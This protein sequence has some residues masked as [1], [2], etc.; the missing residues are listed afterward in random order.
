MPTEVATEITDSPAEALPVPAAQSPQKPNAALSALKRVPKWAYMAAISVILIIAIFTVYSFLTSEPA[1][2]RIVY[3]HNFRSADIS[4]VVDGTVVYSDTV[5]GGSKRRFGIL[6]KTGASLARTVGVPTGTHAVQ[7]HV[8]AA[9]DGF[10]Q[11]KVSYAEFTATSDNVLRITSLKRG[12]LNLAFEGGAVSKAPG[13]D[14]DSK[15]YSKSVFSVFFSVLGT[16]LSASV[17]FMVQ[18]FWRSHKQRLAK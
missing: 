9:G 12:G 16:M 10:D 14:P 6:D 11:A 13:L 18:E 3:Q 17:S 1:K 8:R 5:S 7:V 4:V 2:L 15:P